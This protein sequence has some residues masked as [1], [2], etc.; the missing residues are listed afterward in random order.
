MYTRQVGADDRV[1]YKMAL[2]KVAVFATLIF[3]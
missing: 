3:Q 2:E 1:G